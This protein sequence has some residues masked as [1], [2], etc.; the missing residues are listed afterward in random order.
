MFAYGSNAEDNGISQI[1]VISE[2]FSHEKSGVE[3]AEKIGIRSSHEG[4]INT[5]YNVYV[6]GW[7]VV[8]SQIH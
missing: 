7:L 1:H 4:L 3:R 6:Y 2:D 5:A 8:M